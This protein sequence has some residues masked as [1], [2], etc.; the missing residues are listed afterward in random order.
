MIPLDI[1]LSHIIEYYLHLA[2]R[3][4]RR[5]SIDLWTHHPSRYADGEEWIQDLY[6]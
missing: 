6:A 3:D 2:L 1:G 5:V 4:N